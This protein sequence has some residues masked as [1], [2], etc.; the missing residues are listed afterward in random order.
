[1]SCLDYTATRVVKCPL[2]VCR[3]GVGSYDEKKSI[4]PRPP[5]TLPCLQAAPSTQDR[6]RQQQQQKQQQQNKKTLPSLFSPCRIDPSTGRYDR[7]GGRKGGRGAHGCTPSRSRES[8]D[9]VGGNTSLDFC[10]RRRCNDRTLIILLHT[11][12]CYHTRRTKGGT[13][14]ASKAS[15]SAPAVTLSRTANIFSLARTRGAKTHNSQQTLPRYSSD[16]EPL[17]GIT[18]LLTQWP[19]ISTTVCWAQKVDAGITAILTEWPKISTTVCWAQKFDAGPADRLPTGGVLCSREAD[20]LLQRS[21]ANGLLRRTQNSGARKCSCNFSSYNI[22]ELGSPVKLQPFDRPYASQQ[23][24]GSS[25]QNST[26][27]QIHQLACRYKH[28]CT[29]V[30]A[31]PAPN[32]KKL[33]KK[34]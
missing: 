19:K 21:C 23:R 11:I 12:D 17:I 10:W 27:C 8:G 4:H 1:M 20:D 16:G 26:S 15:Y 32:N 9:V 3:R 34:K 2:P 31:G 29:S 25:P 13:R 18:A 30:R 5:S 7:A 33:G 6:E 14:V 28:A 24:G 22:L